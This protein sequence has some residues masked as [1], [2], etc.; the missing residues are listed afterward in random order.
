MKYKNIRYLPIVSFIW[1]FTTVFIGGINYPHYNHMTQFISELGANG[2]P[3]NFFI[4]YLGLVLVEIFLIVYLV[5]LL[6]HYS[7]N[8]IS[9]I[10]IYLLLMYCF[11][12]TVAAVFP[13]EYEFSTR[14][15]SLSQSIHT[16]AGGFAYLSGIVGIIV[17]SIG[18]KIFSDDKKI[19]IYGLILSTI[20]LICFTLLNVENE[21][22][23]LFQ[24]I[25]EVSMY[26]WII[27]F[28]MKF[29]YGVP[30]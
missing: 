15:Y 30:S 14:N 12:L 2:A 16:I 22:D 23:G 20:S 7:L 3:N 17:L 19:L 11:L 1:L 13:I 6:K 9:R 25:L 24:R 21:L 18:Y 8:R 10:G 5:F 27:I 29:R 4:N 26:L 28:S